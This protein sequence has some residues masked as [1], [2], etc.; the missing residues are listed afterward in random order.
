MRAAFTNDYY[1]TSTGGSLLPDEVL[2]RTK[3]AFSD[4][5][6][7]KS[8]SLYQIIQDHCNTQFL[9]DHITKIAGIGL[10]SEIFSVVAQTDPVM[11][12]IGNHLIPKTAEQYYYRKIFETNYKGM[13]HMIPYF[14]MPKYANNIVDPSART[15]EIYTETEETEDSAKSS[16]ELDAV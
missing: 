4:G 6:S 14:W 2:W 12:K 5:V 7:S 3:E 9:K 8:R 11:N 1:K 10:T 16:V 15:L 13:G